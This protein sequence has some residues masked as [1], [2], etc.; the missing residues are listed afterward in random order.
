MA[1]GYTLGDG[2]GAEIVGTFL[3]VYTVYS[4][5]DAKRKARDSFV[6][7]SHIYSLTHIR[8]YHYIR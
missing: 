8:H 5:T 2:L 1:H 3:L 7:V 4:A 6:P